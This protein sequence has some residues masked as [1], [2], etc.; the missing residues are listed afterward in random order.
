MFKNLLLITFTIL[1]SASLYL[2]VHAQ[3]A[4]NH[5][6][7]GL[8]SKYLQ[9]LSNAELNDL[10]APFR[11]IVLRLNEKYNV[12]INYHDANDCEFVRN[13]MIN[14]I[15]Y[16]SYEDF[17]EGVMVIVNILLRSHLFNSMLAEVSAAQNAGYISEDVAFDLRMLIA[18]KSSDLGDLQKFA[19]IF[20]IENFYTIKNPSQGL[21][22]LVPHAQ[23]RTRWIR[24]V[25]PLLQ[26]IFLFD[27]SI[28]V[29]EVNEGL[30]WRY[31]RY[32][33]PPFAEHNVR[34][35]LPGWRISRQQWYPIGWSVVSYEFGILFTHTG[36]HGTTENDL[37]WLFSLPHPRS[38]GL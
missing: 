10:Y 4:E 20:E 8:S 35:T 13:F 23:L 26:G 37:F 32:T 38:T 16:E 22:E 11:S 9:T 36:P 30:G 27:L 12:E 19:E 31:L 28:F 3:E 1:V 21:Y 29:D 24:Q 18:E 15:A 17:I 6:I 5:P 2:N 25:S 14:T 33:Q 34:T 7:R